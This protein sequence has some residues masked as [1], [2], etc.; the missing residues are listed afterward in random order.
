MLLF[1][2]TTLA[3]NDVCVMQANRTEDP[4]TSSCWRPGR[5]RREEE[6]VNK[7]ANVSAEVLPRRPLYLHPPPPDEAIPT[8]PSHCRK[9]DGKLKT[10]IKKTMETSLASWLL[11]SQLTQPDLP[12]YWFRQDQIYCNQSKAQIPRMNGR[13]HARKGQRFEMTRF[14]FWICRHTTQ[15]NTYTLVAY[16]E[17]S[18]LRFDTMSPHHWEAS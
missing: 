3:L 18:E 13:T 11:S 9:R 2:V 5:K 8:S 16:L 6:D 7:E 14:K 15:H 17:L 4:L 10:K 12:S 1:I